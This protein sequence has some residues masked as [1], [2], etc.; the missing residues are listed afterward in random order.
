LYRARTINPEMKGIYLGSLDSMEGRFLMRS[1]FHG[2]YNPE[3]HLLYLS[4]GALM[5]RRLE[6]EQGRF[7]G[8]SVSLAEGVAYDTRFDRGLFSVSETGVVVFRHGRGNSELVWL[9]RQGNELGTLGSPGDYRDVHISPDGT[10]VAF[11]RIDLEAGNLND[12]WLHDLTLDTS[13]RFTFDP[14]NDRFPLWSPGGRDIYFAS[15]RD[16][17][18]DYKLHKKAAV[19]EGAVEPV[20]DVVAWPMDISRDG[21]YLTYVSDGDLWIWSIA[22]GEEPSVLIENDFEKN[23]GRF[24]PDGGWIAYVSNETGQFEVYVRSYPGGEGRYRISTNGGHQPQWSTDGKELFYIASDGMMMRVP[25]GTGT[26]FVSDAPE[27]L[28]DTG[29]NAA[30]LSRIL[31]A[32]QAYSITPDAQRFL[33]NRPIKI[34]EPIT[35]ILNW[36]KDLQ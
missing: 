33:L 22:G 13:T 6:L 17:E 18:G 25:V 5:A 4:D 14:E 21:R 10:R 35:V 15:I 16:P 28:F 24:S 12:I 9:D 2:A 1:S 31:T 23:G 34:E 36:A 8:E 27:P 7:E 30:D 19:G 26:R 32:G 11:A 3:G 20:L 29:W